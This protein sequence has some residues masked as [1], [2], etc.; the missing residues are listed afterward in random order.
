PVTRILPVKNSG[1]FKVS[2]NWDEDFA[3][4][5]SGFTH[6]RRNPYHQPYR[7]NT[8]TKLSAPDGINIAASPPTA[9]PE[10][11][12]TIPSVSDFVIFFPLFKPV[13]YFCPSSITKIGDG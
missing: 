7:A 12:L 5:I 3:L 13:N 10:S 2:F 4:K 1:Q 11:A 6:L 8:G 9:T